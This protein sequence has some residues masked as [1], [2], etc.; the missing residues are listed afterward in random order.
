MFV[1]LKTVVLLSWHESFFDVAIDFFVKLN[2]VT[3]GE[4]IL[5][6]TLCEAMYDNNYKS[7]VKGKKV[8]VIK[9]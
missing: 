6:S 8:R 9:K 5:P 7:T 3:P 2:A 1:E 4:Y